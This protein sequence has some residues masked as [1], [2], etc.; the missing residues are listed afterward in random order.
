MLRKII[1]IA[2]INA[3]FPFRGV[4]EPV[5]GGSALVIQMKNVDAES[6]VD[7]AS[8]TRTNLPGKKEPDWLRE[9]D[10]IFAARGSKNYAALIDRVPENAV[11]SPHFFVLRVR[12]DAMTLPAFLAWQI[13]QVP[14]RKYFEQSATGSYILN[15]RRQVLE[16]LEIVVP[17]KVRQGI[18]VAL[19][20]AARSER[21]ILE[22]LIAN[23]K[24][25][26]EA[27]ALGLQEKFGGLTL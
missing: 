13:N 17:D 22:R 27:I 9:D 14:A 10:I 4:V 24:T 2:T 21:N 8:T 6:G 15:I 20:Q 7:W 18:I 26:M 16:N 19:N 25:Q 11:C 5:P 23:R 12:D 1:D 3:G